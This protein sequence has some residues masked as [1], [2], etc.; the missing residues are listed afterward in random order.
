[1][2]YME[3]RRTLDGRFGAWTHAWC[4][5]LEREGDCSID[6]LILPRESGGAGEFLGN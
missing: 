3:C 1:M 6:Y 4:V 5:H 2:V